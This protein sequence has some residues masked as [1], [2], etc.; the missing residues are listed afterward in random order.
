VR[1]RRRAAGGGA[2]GAVKCEATLE[3]RQFFERLLDSRTTESYFIA[4]LKDQDGAATVH[5]TH[6][7]LRLKRRGESNAQS[8]ARALER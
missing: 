8:N 2:L 6:H 7:G 4:W 5:R 1:T 3:A